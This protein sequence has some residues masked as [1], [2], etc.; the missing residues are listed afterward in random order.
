MQKIT[1]LFFLFLVNLVVSQTTIYQ[2]SF[3]TDTNGTNYNTTIAEFSD[4]GNDY[5]TRTD[6]TNI[7]TNVEITGIDGSFFFGAQDIDGEGAALP[8]FLSTASVDVSSLNSV[9]FV[10]DLAE[11]ADGTSLDWDAA[12]YVHIFYSLDG[13]A[14]Q[15]LLWIE[16]DIDSGS[17][18]NAAEDTDFDGI[19]DGA[20]LTDVLTS[21]N[22]SIDVSSAS[23]IEIIIEF[24]LNSGDEDIALDNIRLVDGFVA[25]PSI[26]ISSP[27]DGNTFAPGTT[28]VDVE[29]LTNNLGP[30]DQVDITVN[31]TTTQNVTSPFTISTTDGSAYTVQ[32]EV[33]SNNTIAADDLI[34]FDVAQL[35]QV[36]DITALRADVNTNGLGRYY[37]ITGGMTFTFGD[38]F[39]N[40]KW[41]QDNTPS[42][43]Y[44]ED[45]DGIIAND[46]YAEG[47]QVSGLKGSTIDDNG[48]LTFIP[49]EDSGSVTGSVSV[50][51]L[52][53]SISEFNANFET[54]ES[55]LVGFQNV[56]FTEGDGTATFNTG[57]NYEFGNG[58]DVSEMRTT[59]FGAD[60]I[61]TLIPSGQIAGLAG[62]AAEFNGSPQLY[63]RDLMDID[64]VLSVNSIDNKRFSVYP[65]PVSEGVLNI[66]TNNNSPYSVEIYNLFGKRVIS[67]DNVTNQQLNI[68]KLQ[69]G[70][71]LVRIN[72]NGNTAT[73]KLV[74]K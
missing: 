44:V 48:V 13:G 32:V 25:S 70:V 59:F 51:P 68:E 3:E 41:F 58:T 50:S 73:Q 10:I 74:V 28:S 24:N 72:Q 18:S 29:F 39:Q 9:D 42:G 20:V 36:P 21:F 19:G 30:T 31:G 46:V 54:Y 26:T 17:N 11:D 16:A 47:D 33:V 69:N 23:S 35:I 71:Y 67:L 65:N 52:V 55:L 1:L 40:R 15:N 64:V 56:T 8:V 4:G 22:K 34:L 43:I 49:F 45:Q 6:G 2:E 38:G 27:S 57:T 66:V 5:F 60:Y 37:E 61:G 62:L 12:D 14:N 7:A 63:S 53:L